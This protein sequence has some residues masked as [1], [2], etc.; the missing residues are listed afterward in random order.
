MGAIQF[1]SYSFVIKIC[2]LSAVHPCAQH[3]PGN[4]HLV[5]VWLNTLHL[6][7]AIT[8]FEILYLSKTINGWIRLR[9]QVGSGKWLE[10]C[11]WMF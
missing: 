8:P 2:K 5:K 4:Y 1:C 3:F 7:Q 11:L 10:T 6:C 9:I